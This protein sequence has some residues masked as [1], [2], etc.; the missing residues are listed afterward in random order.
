MS[1]D[2]AMVSQSDVPFLHTFASEV[3]VAMPASYLPKLELRAVEG[4]EER[5]SSCPHKNE[6]GGL[7]R[8]LNIDC[9]SQS[10][11]QPLPPV[12]QYSSER[13]TAVPL[14]T[15][16]VSV[17]PPTMSTYPL[18]NVTVAGSN[19]AVAQL[20]GSSMLPVMPQ[21]PVVGLYSSAL[22]IRDPVATPPAT[23]TFPLGNRVP[24][25]SV[26]AVDMLPVSVHVPEVGL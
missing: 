15:M 7:C 23:S 19:M 9:W 18:V 11:G 26:R 1:D 5:H 21:V 4:N 25:C 10:R 3:S 17:Y 13:D 24:V 8:L 22:K 12:Y 6:T 14:P 16:L 2:P 20:R